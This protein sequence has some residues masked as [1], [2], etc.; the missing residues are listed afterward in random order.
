M[1]Q[2]LTGADLASELA[3]TQAIVTSWWQTSGHEDPMD[4]VI[5]AYWGSHTLHE[6]L[7]REVWHTAQHTRQVMMFLDQLGIVADRPLT[8]EDLAGLPLPER[9]WD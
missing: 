2:T 9:V 3:E 7:E 6:V 8:A 4:R 1:P 5:D